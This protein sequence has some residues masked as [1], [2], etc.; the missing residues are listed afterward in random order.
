MDLSAPYRSTVP[1]GVTVIADPF[2][3]VQSANKKT[4]AAFRR[5]SYRT[6]HDYKKPGLPRP[7]HAMLR[8]NVEDLAPDHLDIILDT[9]DSDADGQQI[10]VV[11]IA[12]EQLR[13][14]LALR[15]TKT[16][17]SPA[18]SAPSAAGS[19]P[20]TCGAPATTTSPN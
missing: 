18:P 1:A 16:G 20:S 12:K 4:D 14:L 6:E 13:K 9:L 19:P 2:H 11:W 10:A 17:S 15:V 3:L 5:L 7:L 8:H